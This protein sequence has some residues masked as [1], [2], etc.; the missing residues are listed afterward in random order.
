MFYASF[1]LF[2]V[3][4]D[5]FAFLARPHDEISVAILLVLAPLAHVL[6]AV[7]E[8][9]RPLPLLH[10]VHEVPLVYSAIA[11]VKL[12]LSMSDGHGF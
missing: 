11:P 8:V 5:S 9:Q 1:Y 2:S 4:P 12:S 10:V 7:R 3:L 6:P